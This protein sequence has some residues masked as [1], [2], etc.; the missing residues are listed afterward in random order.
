MANY[1]YE[2]GKFAAADPN[3]L[4]LGFNKYVKY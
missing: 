2:T 4:F 3:F 1:F